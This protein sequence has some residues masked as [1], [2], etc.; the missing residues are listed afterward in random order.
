M[1]ELVIYHRSDLD[2]ICCREIAGRALPQAILLGF[3]YEDPLPDL[4]LYEI[5]YLLDISLPEDVMRKNAN[6]I[7]W[8]DHHKSILEKLA[9]TKFAG[10]Q[11]DGVAACRLAW[12]FFF[13]WIPASGDALPNKEM[14]VDH[15]VTEPYA[16]QL[17]GEYDIWDKRN[18]EVDLFQ[19]GMQAE[20]SPNWDSLLCHGDGGYGQRYSNETYV[21]L[22]LTAGKA[23]SQYVK[24]TNSEIIIQRGFDVAWEGLNFRA[25]NIAK[26]NS[27]TF[28]AALKSEH[29]ACLAYFW[30]GSKWRFSL[31]HAP[32]KEYHDLSKIAVKYG[33]GG[34]RGAAGFSLSNLP[35][36]FGA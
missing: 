15:K 28:L 10:H 8:V 2:G 20:E 14:Y 6:K 13:E 25:L 11:I 33:G 29:D 27:M 35:V 3:E 24:V 12:Q 26:C 34:H 19:L 18:P 21:A 32:G 36:E 16:V 31:Y 1:K 30:N 22:I 5:V 7:V 9:D 23:I 17:L 4:S